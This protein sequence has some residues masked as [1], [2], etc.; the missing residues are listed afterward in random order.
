MFVK[1]QTFKEGKNKVKVKYNSPI[2]LVKEFNE[3]DVITASIQDD[4]EGFD[5]SW[6]GN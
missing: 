3:A 5:L 2:I 6:I 1:I 4:A